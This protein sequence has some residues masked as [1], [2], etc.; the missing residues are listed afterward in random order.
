MTIKHFVFNAFSE[1]TFVAYDHT[2]E[3]VI[4]DPGCFDSEEKSTLKMFISD[5]HLKVKKLLN[6][7]CHIDHVLGNHF[8]K[9]TYGVQLHIHRAD[10]PTLKANEI[11]AP[12]YGFQGYEPTTAEL[13]LEEGDEVRFGESVLKV[14]FVPGH[15]PGHVA[16]VNAEEKICICGDVLFY[17]SIGRTDLPGGD[18][19]TLISSIKD[20]LF[21]LADDTKVF[22]GHGQATSIGFEKQYNPY[23]GSGISI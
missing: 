18:Y 23:C 12:L 16:F 22:C 20:K 17:Q 2:G 1:N 10:I 19:A 15:A 5:N 7:H 9:Q 4:I 3:C 21:T 13:F 6:T 14:L 8:V 11:V